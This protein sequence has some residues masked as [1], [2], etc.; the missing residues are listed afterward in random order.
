M[1]H[2]NGVLITCDDFVRGR[3]RET[4]DERRGERGG[5]IKTAPGVPGS[6]P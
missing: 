3:R 2:C 4:T 5:V 6:P 1:V